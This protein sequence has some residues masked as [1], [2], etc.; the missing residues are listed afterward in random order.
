MPEV[1]VFA[2]GYPSWAEL[3]SPDPDR[4]KRFYRGLFGWNSYT[5]TVGGLGDYEIFT[6]GGVQGPEVAGMQ[7]LADDSGTASWTCYFRS[8]DLP[9]TLAAVRLAGGLVTVEPLQVADLGVL[10]LCGDLEGADFGLWDAGRL[11]GAGVVDEPSAMIW[12]ELAAR[13]VEG[14]CRFYGEV[15]GWTAVERDHDGSPYTYW[16]IDGRDVAG[17]TRIDGSWPAEEPSH[18][19][20]FFWTVDCDVFTDRAAG[21]GATVRTPPTDHDL[22]RFCVLVDPTGARLGLFTPTVDIAAERLR[23]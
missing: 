4:S 5:L 3:A 1:T 11:K 9:A 23:P 14:A 10:A 19:T 15:F 18:W 6:L 22:G 20:P 13:D 7:A 8:D 17:L 21:L 2:P 16:K 12:V